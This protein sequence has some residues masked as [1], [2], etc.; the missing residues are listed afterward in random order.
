MKNRHQ[1]VWQCRNVKWLLLLFLIL[2]LQGAFAQG[3]ANLVFNVTTPRLA[4]IDIEP[5][6]NN[7]VTLQIT[8]S[9]EAGES[10]GTFPANS[11]LWINYT[12]AKSNSDPF[13]KVNVQVNGTIPAGITLKIAASA[14]TG[15][16]RGQR[17]TPTGSPVT[18][19][20]TPQTLISGIGGSFTGDGIGN[21]HQL[22]FTIDI[23]NFNILN[24]SPNTT[25]QVIYTL[26]DN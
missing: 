13:K 1:I 21:G 19:S 26:A 25:L 2:P 7:N 4:L 11:D 14:A 6:S 17:G 3:S 5:S 24:V 8:P 23:P 10:T 9:P 22:T 16:G 15:F 18:L 20:N 12:C